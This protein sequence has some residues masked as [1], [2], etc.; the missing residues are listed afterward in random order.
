MST[1]HA[2]A[3]RVTAQRPDPLTPEMLRTTV[4]ALPGLADPRRAVPLPFGTTDLLEA[5]PFPAR[6]AAGSAP[7]HDRLGHALVTAFGLQR[8][9][10]HNSYNDH[11]GIPSVRSTFPVH[12]FLAR[13]GRHYWLDVYRHALLDMGVTARP[14]DSGRVL[15]AAR[16][17]HLPAAYG[18]LRGALT[19][20]E[21]GIGLRALCLALDLFGVPYQ[22]DMPGHGSP[23]YLAELRL[24]PVGEWTRPI[25][26]RTAQGNA[27]PPA[28]DAPGPDAPGPD[29]GPNDPRLRTVIAAN[30][31]MLGRSA[32]SLM[33]HAPA[34]PDAGAPPGIA[35]SWA[36]V[37]WARSSGTMPRGLSGVAA[38][39]RGQP[40]SM[41]RSGLEWLG[42]PPPSGL[43]RQVTAALTVT[44]GLQDIEGTTP[45]LYRLDGSALSLIS[46]HET[47]GAA[48]ER[49]YPHR[50]AN[51]V[52]CGVRLAN[53]NWLISVRPGRL[54]RELGPLATSL[55]L[56]AAGW[57]TQG[58]CLAAAAHG[59]YARPSRAFQ[60]VPG[61]LLGLA[62]DETILIG[63][64]CGT[65]RF[66]QST[67][68]LRL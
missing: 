28:S 35:K 67:L 58:L 50:Q 62:P 1:D 60:E 47:I 22:V 5:S 36:E 38:R 42:V 23:E 19:E 11:R 15:L 6:Q 59:L 9:E 17:S 68:D 7:G 48:L 40:F 39:R 10:P 12:A 55:A 66:N 4:G 54:D 13:S 34:R 56:L 51:D 18:T 57:M 37:L 44:V 46:R 20:L 52:G 29:A 45:G 21:L 43:L 53:A 65:P 30:R 3:T 32:D 49:E 8:R 25:V 61:R 31:A 27:V 24:D 16:Y 2:E 63:V 64:T 33:P 26:V 14:A 41:V